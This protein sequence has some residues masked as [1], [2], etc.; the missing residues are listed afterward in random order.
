[1]MKPRHFSAGAIALTLALT[2]CGEQAKPEFLSHRPAEPKATEAVQAEPVEQAEAQASAEPEPMAETI[3]PETVEVA[4][5]PTEPEVKAEPIAEATVA[6]PTQADPIQAAPAQVAPIQAATTE[7]YPGEVRFSEP[8]QAHFSL[9]VAH[10]N[11]THSNFDPVAGSLSS[12]AIGTDPVY[13]R[14]GG[15]PRLLT[16]VNAIKAAAEQHDQGLLFLHGG[17]A[18]Q[19]TGYFK[20]NNG[21]MNA[22]ILSRMGLDAMAVGNH[23]FDLNNATLAQFIDNVNF[24]MLG[25]NMDV[26]ADPDLKDSSNLFP[27]VVYAFEGNQKTLITDTDALPQDKQLVAVLGL[28][29]EDMPS[30]SP[31]VGEVTFSGEIETAQAVVEEIQALGINTIVAVTH[32]GLARDQAIARNVE[33][34]DAIVGGHSHSLLGDFSNIGWGDGGQYAEVITGPNGHQT[35]VVQAGQYAQAVGHAQLGFDEN[36]ALTQCIGGNTLL[37]DD[38]FFADGQHQQALTGEALDSVNAFVEAEPNIAK[39]AEDAE[40]RAHIDQAYR[41]EL[42]AAY[43][44]II[45]QIPES[46]VHERRPHDGGV[47]QHGSRVAP[48]VAESQLYFANLP[49]V[50]EASGMTVDF[51]LVGAGG[52]RTSLDEGVYYEGSASMELLPFSNYLSILKV[53]GSAIIEMIE[54]TVTKSLADDAHKGKFPYGGG[55]RYHFVETSAQVE[56]ELVSVEV[57]REGQYE[58]KWEALDP[59]AHYTIVTTNYNANGNDDWDAL[60][61]AQ[62]QWVERMDIAFLNDQVKAYPVSKVVRQGDGYAA[63]YPNGQPQCELV[64]IRCSSDAQAFIEYIRQVHPTVTELS[65]PAVTLELNR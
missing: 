32:L 2:G 37:S 18:W 60:F 4:A 59:R 9:S 3:E 8:A 10:I 36:G 41:P 23:E 52:I 56:G 46:L 61:R 30:I 24:P 1:M 7:Q 6:V 17:D 14:F 65:T 15:H 31:H 29:L 44:E 48:L 45:G 27:Y 5:E 64:E 63:V 39:V 12:D 28:V 62:S 42:T 51:A 34:I 55:L 43:G 13:T 49:E 19:G 26:S 35:C 40:L 50:Q 22:D 21:K 16:Q 58:A 54:N 38:R 20:L 25:A 47:D 57:R 11:D 33:G 53:P